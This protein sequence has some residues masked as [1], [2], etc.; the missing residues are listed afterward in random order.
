[1][2][3][4]PTA[5]PSASAR[6]RCAH[7][8][9]RCAP[10]YRKKRQRGFISIVRADEIGEPGKRWLEGIEII[11]WRACWGRRWWPWQSTRGK[12]EDEG[13]RYRRED[14][15]IREGRSELKADGVAA[16]RSG[17]DGG[18]Q[19]HSKVTSSDNELG[20]WGDWSQQRR[21]WWLRV[22]AVGGVGIERSI[23]GGRALSRRL[24]SRKWK[25]KCVRVRPYWKVS[26]GA[27]KD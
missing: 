8:R 4:P 26:T 21:R 3:Q 12:A 23:A 19:P 13:G 18:E 11:S 24:Q 9:W 6:S 5:P 2:D 22:I 10:P 25:D 14:G 7:A 1:M 16:R 27:A 17:A 15:T 20:L